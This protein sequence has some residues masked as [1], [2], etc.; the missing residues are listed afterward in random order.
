MP[1]LPWLSPLTEVSFLPTPTGTRLRGVG[2]GHL[3]A[4]GAPW[5]FPVAAA[6]EAEQ[7]IRTKALYKELSTLKN[8]LISLLRALR[9]TRS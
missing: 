7:S 2:V 8:F 3:G 5:A 4:E 6:R 9:G 1:P